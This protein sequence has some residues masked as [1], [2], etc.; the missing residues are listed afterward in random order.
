MMEFLRAS[1]LGIE[2]VLKMESKKAEGTGLTMAPMRA[3]MM[4][5]TKAGEMESTKAG[6]M[7]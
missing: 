2:R 7:E 1:Y 6:E 5:S 3:A 4:E